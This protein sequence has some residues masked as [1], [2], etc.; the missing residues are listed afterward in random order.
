MRAFTADP[1]SDDLVERAVA[2]AQCAATSSWIQAYHL[3]QITDAERRA[4]L[5]GLTGGQAQVAEAGAFFIVCGDLRRHQR[6]AE[7]AGAPR[8]EGTETFLLA[9]IDASLFA[10]NLVL[11]FEAMGL[12]ACY[13]G[14]LRND[15]AAVAE[16]VDLPSGVLPIFGLTVGWP[17]EPPGEDS[18]RP[19]LRP[20]DVWTKDAYPT[21][22]ELDRTID[23]FDV[24][25]VRYYRARGED[26]GG[27]RNWS[28]GVWRKF[29]RPLRESLR[30]FYESQGASL[31]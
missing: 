28:G 12:G 1:V 29:Q 19:R 27:K 31:D 21:D 7:R 16:Q 23:A 9:V 30:A 13:I 18:L 26:K 17:A 22:A 14:G 20:T 24:V 2:A 8:A 25:A 4:A 11:A 5:V 10:Q 15:L 6:I 3:L